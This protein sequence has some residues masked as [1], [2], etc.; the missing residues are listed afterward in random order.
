MRSLSYSKYSDVT[1]FSIHGPNNTFFEIAPIDKTK[2]R[3]MIEKKSYITN[4]TD[5]DKLRELQLLTTINFFYIC[6]SKNQQSGIFYLYYSKSKII[7]SSNRN[8][9]MV[10]RIRWTLL[11]LSKRFGNY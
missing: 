3:E 8:I 9:V 4:L 2:A 5:D 1:N 6:R 11:K 7:T 10:D